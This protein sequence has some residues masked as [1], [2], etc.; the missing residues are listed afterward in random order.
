[1]TEGAAM[2][3][4]PGAWR[5]LSLGMVVLALLLW[6]WGRGSKAEQ[7][8]EQQANKPKELTRLYY[9]VDTC[10]I[11]HTEPLKGQNPL[12]CKCNEVHTW[13]LHDKH[14]DAWKVLLG[15]RA[16]QM[17]KLLG[18]DEVEI[19]VY[20]T[21]S[22][23]TAQKRVNSVVTRAE[24]VRCH[25]LYIDDPS[26]VQGTTFRKEEGVSCCVCHGA[27][28]EWIV[29][30]F[31]VTAKDN[32]KWRAEKSREVKERD[33]GMRDLWDP[34]KRA[35][36]CFS[37]HVGNTKEGKFVTHA[38]YAAGH[39]PLP[40]I[41]LA[42]FSEEMPRHWLYAGEK[43]PEVRK[44]FDFDEE[45]AKFERSQLVLVG[46]AAAL[47]E[48]LNLV[49]TQ[50]QKAAEAKDPDDQALD[51]ALFD[52][53]A[54]H[55][56]LKTPAWRSQRGYPGKP[57]RPHLQPW[58]TV[59]V[60]SGLRSLDSDET[61]LDQALGSLLKVF[62]SRP[63]G[64]PVKAAEEAGKAVA[65]T[66]TLIA[67]L[68]ERKLDRLAA[69]KVLSNLAILKD[70][71][72]PDYDSARQRAWGYLMVCSETKGRAYKDIKQASEG[73]DKVLKLSLPATRSQQLEMD[74]P[75]ALRQRAEYD[76]EVFKREFRKFTVET[77]KP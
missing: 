15:P 56:E 37:C 77:S 74:L 6:C 11:C 24:C 23:K 22:K 76:P 58:P 27:Y 55:H 31:D 8:G 63:F 17:G 67:R 47:R 30:H 7:R 14:A 42:T 40:G 45:Q 36:L 33:F 16:Q 49:A 68:I 29:A 54:C 26:H 50:A 5:G 60:R 2:S 43:K 41:E 52:C 66:D 1:M 53:Y 3:K 32:E 59:L 13:E 34:S 51:L 21:E 44:L 64:D 38:M 70:N 72:Y 73:L 61:Q 65:W 35:Q 57:G 9:G 75:A 62:D 46:G 19:D 4:L 39:P 71:E 18:W 10:R 12:L 69:E 48:S 25:G 20:D 28:K